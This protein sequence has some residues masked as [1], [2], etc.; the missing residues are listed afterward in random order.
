MIDSQ[1][2]IRGRVSIIDA[3]IVLV[4][5]ALAVGFAY[6]RGAAP[7][8][9]ILRADDTVYVT[10]E[11]N[12]I[13]SIIAADSVVVGDK[14]FRQH[15]THQPLG[16]I[17]AVEH[18][19]ATE[20]MQRADGTAVLAPMDGR[21]SLRITIESTGNVRDAGFFANGNDHLA[22]NGEVALINHRVIFPLARV[23]SIEEERP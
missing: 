4:V 16:T 3:V 10:F 15:A 8:A 14:L 9:S 6:R 2:K 11:V 22:P 5:L 23:Y 21:Y 12:R 1:G 17:V 7:I 13:R 20:V 18:L 19:P